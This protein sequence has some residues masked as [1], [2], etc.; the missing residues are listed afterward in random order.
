[1]AVPLSCILA[2]SSRSKHFI[3]LTACHGEPGYGALPGL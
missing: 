2:G 1:M 3:G